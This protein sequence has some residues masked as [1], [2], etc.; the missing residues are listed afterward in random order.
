MNSSQNTPRWSQNHIQTWTVS[1]HCRMALQ[2]KPQGKKDVEIPG[3]QLIIDAIQ[4]MINIPDCTIIQQLQQVTSQDEHLQELKDNI[5]RGW[6]EN[7]DQ[8]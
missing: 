1:F 8:I 7:K 2:T 4:T 6:P 3:M 5:I